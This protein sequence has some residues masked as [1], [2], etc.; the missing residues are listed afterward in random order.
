M[1]EHVLYKSLRTAVR[2]ASLA[3][4]FVLGRTSGAAGSA[5]ARAT[6]ASSSLPEVVRD[7][8]ES[9]V[10]ALVRPH[11]LGG[12]AFDMPW[13]PG[14]CRKSLGDF[15]RMGLGGKAPPFPTPEEVT[16]DLPPPVQPDLEAIASHSARDPMRVTWVGH[17]T[18]LLQIAGVNVLTDPVFSDSIGPL[19]HLQNWPLGRLRY[20]GMPR[21]TPAA[22]SVKDLPA[23]DV[24]LISH[25][26]HDHLDA[27]SV[28]RIGNGPLWIVPVGTKRFLKSWGISN[29]VEVNWWD[30]VPLVGGKIKV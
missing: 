15:V 23:L 13:A 17:S 12:L 22:L 6:S 10:R 26:H 20:F 29:C 28:K 21:Y 30:H 2:C 18:V 4:D 27:P 7:K 24:V 5:G 16:R 8:D 1:A 14:A 11:P 9:L 25:A 3:S 19:R